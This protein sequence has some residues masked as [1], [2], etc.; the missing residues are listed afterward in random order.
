MTDTAELPAIT[1]PAEF[2]I[3][4]WRNAYLAASDNDGL[5]ALYRTVHLEWYDDGLRFVSTDTYVLV[6]SYAHGDRWADAPVLAPDHDEPPLGAVT[7]IAAD[8][9]MADF[10]KH[11]AAEVKAYARAM[12]EGVP[13]PEVDITFS[14]GTIDE[15]NGGQQRL[16]LGED[17]RRLIVSCDTERIALPIYAG[18]FPTWR[19]IMAGYKPAPRATVAARADI[20]RRIGQLDSRPYSDDQDWLTLTMANGG[21][22]VL[23]T[24]HGRVPL[25]GAFTP[26]RD[27]AAEQAEAA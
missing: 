3:P 12:D 19:K 17:N 18:E 2:V 16:D 26:R 5:T 13:L 14:I 24:G 8:R 7:A 9:L 22:L 25:E 20:L 11:R 4:A 6:A 23:V 21:L 27:E 10:L 15:P 1:L